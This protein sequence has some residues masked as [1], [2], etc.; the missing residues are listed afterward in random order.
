MRKHPNQSIRHKQGKHEFV[1]ASYYL[2]ETNMSKGVGEQWVTFAYPSILTVNIC[3]WRL[4]DCCSDGLIV[5]VSK[6]LQRGEPFF[7]S[8]FCL[9]L[10]YFFIIFL[11]LPPF[12]YQDRANIIIIIIFVHGTF[13][14]VTILP[15][16][17]T[18]VKVKCAMLGSPFEC[19]PSQKVIKVCSR[20]SCHVFSIICPLFFLILT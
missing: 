13:G 17:W 14:I 18:F 7:S 15:H 8:I 16:T 6:G 12:L 2:M 19:V 11:T 20:C 10:I 4:W 9:A 3:G 5:L 1:W